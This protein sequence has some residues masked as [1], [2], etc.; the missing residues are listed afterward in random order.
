MGCLN[1]VG[2]CVFGILLLVAAAA[3]AL[4]IFGLSRL[5]GLL[6]DAVRREFMLPPSSEVIIT[7]G[8]LLDTLQGSVKRFAVDSKEAKINGLKVED[9]EF[10][11][12]GIRFDL[13]RTFLTS[14]AVLTEVANGQLKMKVS[15]QALKERW[16]GE[17]ESKGLS[18]VQVQLKPDGVAVSAV[19]DLKLAKVRVGAKGALVVDGTDRVMLKVNALE[20]GGANLGIAQLKTAFSQLTPVIDL[21]VF[22]MSVAVDQL[23]LYNG[24]L[25]IEA[26]SISLEEKLALDRKRRAQEQAQQQAE[27]DQAAQDEQTAQDAQTKD[28]KS[29]SKVGADAKTKNAAGDVGK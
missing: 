18:N 15:E 27:T 19:I 2:G 12:E 14:Q 5:D 22:K 16:A 13:P 25:R 1:R 21:G 8:T 28:A 10:L 6:A 26:H 11:A 4:Y 20:L 24:Y 9:L 3:V 29:D 23:K 7:R 17:L